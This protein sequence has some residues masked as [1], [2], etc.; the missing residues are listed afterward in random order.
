MACLLLG[1]ETPPPTAQTGAGAW[2]CV[3]SREAALT[4]LEREGAEVIVIGPGIE[5][6]IE[7]AQV[8]HR[9]DA[10]AGLLVIGDEEL[11]LALRAAPLLGRHV[12]YRPNEADLL[13]SVTSMRKQAQR[14]IRNEQTTQRSEGLVTSFIAAT[15]GGRS[16][17]L[18]TLLQ[19]A[20]VGVLLLSTDRRILAANAEAEKILARPRSTLINQNAREFFVVEDHATLDAQLSSHPASNA[21]A[22]L[23]RVVSE[24]HVELASAEVSV[25]SSACLLILNDVTLRQSAQDRAAE[26]ERTLAI[27][28]RSEA[29][30]V[31]AG[32]I[33]HDFN[34]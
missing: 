1:V 3:S 11:R 8:L 24:R 30:G 31:L 32:G 29:L 16:V 5:R 6:P 20:P 26:I 13:E 7:V 10:T 19:S 17:L 22:P 33:A 25:P 2:E 12:R 28:Q 4:Y 18:E 27:T 23:V 21:V 15:R 14:R 34:N 9:A